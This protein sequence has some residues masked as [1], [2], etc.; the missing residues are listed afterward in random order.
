MLK[1]YAYYRMSLCLQ[2]KH[3][4]KK[5]RNEDFLEDN[6]AVMTEHDYAEALKA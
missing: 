3:E 2:G 4:C 1:N 5:L 6:I